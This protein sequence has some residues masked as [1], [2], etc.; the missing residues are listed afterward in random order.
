MKT[1]M[2]STIT[3]FLIFILQGCVEKVH[4]YRVAKN[5]GW[6]FDY[7]KES[8]RNLTPEESVVNTIESGNTQIHERWVEKPR[9]KCGAM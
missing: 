9:G 7:Y 1:F 5:G 4:E 2:I 3:L 6:G 8:Y